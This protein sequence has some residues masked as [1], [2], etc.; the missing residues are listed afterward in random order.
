MS[1]YF[2]NDSRVFFSLQATK[3]HDVFVVKQTRFQL[4]REALVLVEAR[5][6]NSGLSRERGAAEPGRERTGQGRQRIVD[7][8]RR[9]DAEGS[10]TDDVRRR[11]LVGQDHRIRV[12]RRVEEG[13]VV[14]QDPVVGDRIRRRVQRS[15]P[16]SRR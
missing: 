14:L 16:E 12:H 3:V 15:H 1:H 13:L 5:N 9:S 8:S 10:G 2:E 7:R 4:R 6:G 11:V